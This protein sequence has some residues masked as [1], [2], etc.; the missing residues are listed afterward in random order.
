MSIQDKKLMALRIV[1]VLLGLYVTYSFVSS[2]D[3]ASIIMIIVLWV[4]LLVDGLLSR[5]K[6]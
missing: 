5:K 2:G 1:I 6:K 4:A 3:H